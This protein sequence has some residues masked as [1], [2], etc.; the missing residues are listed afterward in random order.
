M[1]EVEQ[2]GSEHVP[3][4][5]S[6]LAFLLELHHLSEPANG[7]PTAQQP[8]QLS[9]SADMGL[10]KNVGLLWVYATGNVCGS[11]LPCGLQ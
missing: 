7:C 11:R 8:C 2:A 5:H 4:A 6:S 9:M 1:Q 3:Y 10:D